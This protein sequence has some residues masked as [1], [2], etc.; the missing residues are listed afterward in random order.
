MN[1]NFIYNGYNVATF[2]YDGDP[3]R[4]K[5][6]WIDIDGNFIGAIRFRGYRPTNEEV[7]EFID[8]YFAEMALGIEP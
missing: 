4:S 1:E 6:L 8:E 2:I 5:E 3:E 7:M